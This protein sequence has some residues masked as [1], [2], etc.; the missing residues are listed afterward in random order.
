MNDDTNQG[1]GFEP[2][3][4]VLDVGGPLVARTCPRCW[5]RA[6]PGEQP[7]LCPAAEEQ[8]GACPMRVAP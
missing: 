3:H 4:K 6:A 8:I 7:P 1:E 2:L 5:L